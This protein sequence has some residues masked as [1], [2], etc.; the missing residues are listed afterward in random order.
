MILSD[1]R[2]YLEERGQTSLGDIALHFDASPEALQGMLDI[3]IRKGKIEKRSATASCGSS[4][5]QC[6]PTATE[7]YVWVKGAV[8]VEPSLPS[9][10]EHH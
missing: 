2:K 7:L 10:C 4:C 9:H 3:W 6:E 5:N 1:L 8:D